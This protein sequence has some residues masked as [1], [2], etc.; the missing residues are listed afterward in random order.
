MSPVQKGSAPP[1][2][3]RQRDTDDESP[4]CK[5]RRARSPRKSDVPAVPVSPTAASSR[6]LRSLLYDG[7]PSILPALICMPDL[8]VD[9]V[10]SSGGLP[11]VVAPPGDTASYS[12]K[13]W[14]GDGMLCSSPVSMGDSEIPIMSK[15]SSDTDPDMEDEFCRFQ[16]LQVAVSHLSTTTDVGVMAWL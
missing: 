1:R 7:Q 6:E 16:P 9:N 2:S 10:T 12:G 8:V 11:S 15:F 3:I 13:V 4:H 5:A 14:S